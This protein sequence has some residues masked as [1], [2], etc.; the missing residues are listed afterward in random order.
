MAFMEELDRGKRESDLHYWLSNG[1]PSDSSKSPQELAEEFCAYATK[2]SNA[3]YRREIE[4]SIGMHQRARAAA[5]AE[6]VRS[7]AS[8]RNIANAS[9]VFNNS[10]AA[11]ETR[12]AGSVPTTPDGRL[13]RV[14]EVA[15]WIFSE[16]PRDGAAPLKKDA[17]KERAKKEGP[18]S[19][20]ADR[21]FDE[22]YRQ[23]YDS[24]RGHYQKT[25]WRLQP[26]YERRL[27]AINGRRRR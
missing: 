24:K 7:T 1:G 18:V 13:I 22:A 9:I 6:Q 5:E 26:R 8:S 19:D 4:I 11:G 21:E 12:A 14:A 17:L 25:G 10:P 3:E 23:V 27:S 20:V 15:E 16:H 2:W